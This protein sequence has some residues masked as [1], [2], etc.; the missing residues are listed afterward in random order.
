M[1][2]ATQPQG[3]EKIRLGSGVG[4]MIIPKEHY[5]SKGITI[6]IK[7]PLQKE[8]AT[9][10]ALLPSVMKSSTE[11][12]ATP[13][14]LA[15]KLQSLYGTGLGVSVDKMGERQILSFR[16]NLV[17]DRYLP[18]PI[19]D[20]ALEVLREVLLCP[21]IKDGGFLPE[22]VTIEKENLAEDI[23]AKINDK[24]RYALDRAIDIMCQDEPYSIS[25]DGYI[26][27][28]ESIDG[29]ALYD[30]YQKVLRESAIDIV[31]AGD[32]EK[33]EIAPKI[34]AL[35]DFP[36]GQILSIPAESPKTPGDLKTHE[37]SMEITQGK[38]VMGYRTQVDLMDEDYYA[39]LVYNAVFGG[40]AH[41][42]LF[43]NVR[44]KHSLAYS[45]YSMQEKF[46]GL[47]I[48]Q[49]GIEINDYDRAVELILAEMTDM[50]TG[51]IT[52]EELSNGK[53]YLVNGLQSMKDSL[54]SLGDFYYNQSLRGK[55]V[56]LEEMVDKIKGIE[57]D[58][59]M[60]VAQKLRPDTIY[61][62]R[63]KH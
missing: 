45:I 2:N 53:K 57:K 8:E 29:K 20:Q 3:Y 62:L 27:D 37:E 23:R 59:L 36:R 24:G 12:Y 14:A 60:R 22:Y 32:F 31:V 48:I 25:E 21:N 52:D 56:T 5:K 47:L 13:M 30:H 9:L 43:L 42:K 58:D 7:R 61:F 63:D 18:E 33:E 10:N 50:K 34:K 11:N 26:E 44:E 1:L 17:G 51:K 49:A 15:K 38:L 35:M 28:L 40:G 39:M 4:L 41:S 6:Y 19:L 54:T 55:N 46:K 16:M